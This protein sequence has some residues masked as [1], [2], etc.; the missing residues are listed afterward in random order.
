[1]MQN[2][3]NFG[4]RFVKKQ[5]VDTPPKQQQSTKKIS[6]WTENKIRAKSLG[7]N[8]TKQQ[9]EHG[10]LVK[11][12]REYTKALMQ[13]VIHSRVI[14]TNKM[15]EKYLKTNMLSIYTEIKEIIE[16]ELLEK[17]EP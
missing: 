10:Q 6:P 5:V 17:K 8:L 7:T 16:S 9:T 12:F 15:I 4:T 11:L 2:I 1:M 14:I 3:K 13:T